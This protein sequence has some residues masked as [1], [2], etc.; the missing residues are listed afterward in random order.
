LHFFVFF[1]QIS[2]DLENHILIINTILA[3]LLRKALEQSS[4]TYKFRSFKM[5][6]QLLIAAVAATMTS[7]AFA[8]ISLTGGMK[9]NYTN[10]E[11]TSAANTNTYKH[12]MDLT[13]K[14]TSGATGVVMVFSNAVSSG[15]A[16][17][18]G[19]TTVVAGSSGSLNSG[20]FTSPSTATTV[21][22]TTGLAV[23]DVY[24]TS[25]IGD[26]NFKI[27]Q[28]QSTSDSNISDATGS[29]RKAGRLTADTTV[30]GVKI[31][32]TDQNASGESIAFSGAVSGVNLSYKMGN[33]NTGTTNVAG[34]SDY[35]DTS[36]SGAVAGVN[37]M[38]RVKDFDANSTA[39]GDLSTWQVSTDINN[40][41]LYA[42]AAESDSA[43]GTFSSEGVLGAIAGAN[44]YSGFGVK[45]S[46]AGNTVKLQRAA[47]NNIS[48]GSDDKSTKI[49]VTRPLA[50]GATF[51]ATYTDG[52]Y[53]GATADKTTLDLELAV[54][55]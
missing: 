11:T 49:V 33:N 31:T 25:S 41:H 54:K 7:V 3:T 48:T 15:N 50:S 28:Y 29:T 22:A 14:G 8:D 30:G 20:T 13:M 47:F 45:T 1:L 34:S 26:I 10:V 4:I 36:I 44:N 9:V 43:T 52:D 2:V 46:M 38:Y 32:F 40:F 19:S 18:T 55:F 23:E 16:A 24:M 39:A 17:N 42:A 37:V 27:G 21:S 53:S 35:T 51:E 12:D 5:K 6:K